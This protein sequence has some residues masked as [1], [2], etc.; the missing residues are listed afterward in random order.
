MAKEEKKVMTTTT[1][2]KA[3]KNAPGMIHVFANL[4][5]G[6]IFQ[7]PKGDGTYRK[8]EI[9]GYSVSDLKRNRERCGQ[10]G[11]TPVKEDDWKE[12]VRIYGKMSM[13]KSGLV[14]AAP[15]VDDGL[16]MARERGDLRHGYEQLDPVTDPRI[17]TTEATKKD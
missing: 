10:F 6:Q 9:A 3:A 1:E 7:L 16:A 8:I 17:K 12:I 13:F 11:I 14:F 5:T 4:P 2:A 15:S